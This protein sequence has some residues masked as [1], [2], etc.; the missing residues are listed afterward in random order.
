MGPPRLEDKPWGDEE[1]YKAPLNFGYLIA[2]I[3]SGADVSSEE[4]G[5][6]HSIYL[7]YL[8]AKWVLSRPGHGPIRIVELPNKLY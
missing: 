6:G 4:A 7:C 5:F 8:S 1:Q 3:S 2:K